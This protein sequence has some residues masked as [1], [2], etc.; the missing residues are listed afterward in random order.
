MRGD[1]NAESGLWCRR[2][3]LPARVEGDPRFGRA[4][5][6]RTG[7]ELGPDGHQCAPVGLLLPSMHEAAARNRVAGLGFP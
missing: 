4:V 3:A 5:H 7:E 6:A 1:R 2:C